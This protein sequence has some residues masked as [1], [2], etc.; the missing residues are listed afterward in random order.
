[1]A[2]QDYY[3]TLEVA[4]DAT[5]AAVKKAYRAMARKYHPDVNPGDKK[6]EAKFK[7]AQRAYDVLSDAE[8]RERY[9]RFG[10]AGVDGMGP[11]GPRNAAAEWAAR[12]AAAQ[13]GGGE[14]F[15]LGDLFGGP[16]GAPGGEVGGGGIFEDLIGRM[17]GG[18]GGRAGRRAPTGPRPGR[19]LEAGLSIPFL[20][21]VHGGETTI[22]VN[23]DGRRESL[24]VKVPA[25][26]ET[27]DKLRL[28]GRGEPGEAGAAAGDLTIL[29]SVL[30]HPFFQRDG[31][32][33]TVDVPVTAAEA[34]LGAK[35][36]VP[37]LDGVRSLTVPPNSS[38]GQK[39]RL[40]GQG[41]PPA[42]D[43][44]GGDLFVA[45]KVVMPKAADEESRRLIR[46]FGE[47]NP[48]R[49]REGLW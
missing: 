10:A 9:D 12:Q 15:D 7:A 31:R 11:N 37:T 25:G 30:P 4:R 45:L 42:G 44:A 48:M 8:K 22:E 38:S 39:L 23:R 18:G 28:R 17:R 16:G 35:V 40:R 24:V 3:E 34:V 27:D 43:R 33:L 32:D 20:T 49:P 13:Q 29:A 47:R 36:D 26:T 46:E 41:M 1:M 21:A 6:A 19:N 5:P 2:E 14:G